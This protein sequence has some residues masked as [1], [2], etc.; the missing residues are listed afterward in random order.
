MSRRLTVRSLAL[1]VILAAT[2]LPIEPARAELGCPEGLPGGASCEDLI[3][4]GNCTDQCS[5]SEQECM[6]GLGEALNNPDCARLC[7]VTEP[8]C[9]EDG[10]DGGEERLYC[11]FEEDYN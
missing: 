10:C 2:G 11:S 5:E 6:E 7:Q 9:Y 8:T 1:A 4:L 3:Y